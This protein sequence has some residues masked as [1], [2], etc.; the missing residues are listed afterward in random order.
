MPVPEFLK[1]FDPETSIV[2][3]YL[4]KDKSGNTYLPVTHPIAEKKILTDNF[5]PGKYVFTHV[6]EEKDGFPLSNQIESMLDEGIV[7]PRNYAIFSASTTFLWGNTDRPATQIVC[8]SPNRWSREDMDKGDKFV[9][10][11]FEG[12]IGLTIQ[13]AAQIASKGASFWLEDERRK[14]LIDSDILSYVPPNHI[15]GLIGLTDRTHGVYKDSIG[16]LG[17]EFLA[18]TKPEN[19]CIHDFVQKNLTTVE[20]DATAPETEESILQALAAAYT[21]NDL[22][23]E[24]ENQLDEIPKYDLRKVR[25]S[26]PWTTRLL[27]TGIE[28]LGNVDLWK[29]NSDLISQKGN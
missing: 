18:G 13:E 23:I 1:D 5:Q 11:W 20:I 26:F 15:I 24:I 25:P 12:M 28:N 2:D 3:P 6:A 22:L 27:E 9:S 10:P 7:S 16:T 4:P 21:Q 19:D 29:Y 14:K 8:R 17:I